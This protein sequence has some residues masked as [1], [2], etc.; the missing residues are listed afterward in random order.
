MPNTRG[1]DLTPR[2]P[3]RPPRHA[4]SD[5]GHALANSG[6]DTRAPQAGL[7]ALTRTAP[8]VPFI[9]MPEVICPRPKYMLTAPAS[10]SP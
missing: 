1:G 5:W 4:E 8:S 3:Y 6:H 2:R 7:N 10:S 9:T